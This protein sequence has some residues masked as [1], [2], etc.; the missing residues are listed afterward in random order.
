LFFLH[1]STQIKLLF[2]GRIGI[3]L[4]SILSSPLSLATLRREDI[5]NMHPL[6][7]IILTGL[8]AIRGTVALLTV[9]LPR[10]ITGD[11]FPIHGN[12]D[13]DRI[14]E[15]VEYEHSAINF[16]DPK[17]G[18]SGI[19]MAYRPY[20]RVGDRSYPLSLKFSGDGGKNWQD[21]ALV[22]WQDNSAQMHHP[23]MLQ[24]PDGQL[25]LAF[26]HAKAESSS[27]APAAPFTGIYIWES[28]D[29]GMSWPTRILV[30]IRS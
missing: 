13:P 28:A 3:I 27:N 20:S 16:R 4:Y 26:L 21:R 12:W 23:S 8:S 2:P 1:Q 7:C 29:G 10:S 19:L 14:G 15:A 17:P 30:C 9:S 11:L 6:L 5:S 18:N 25:L 24:L 22:T